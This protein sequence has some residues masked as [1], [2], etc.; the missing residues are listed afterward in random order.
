MK[1]LMRADELT[2]VGRGLGYKGLEYPLWSGAGLKKEPP[3]LELRVNLFPSRF[4]F[5][6]SLKG[7]LTEL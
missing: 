4:I 6:T 3:T 5:K 7:L 2:K 1:N